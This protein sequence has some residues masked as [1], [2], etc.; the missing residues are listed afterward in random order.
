MSNRRSP[1][2][3][4]CTEACRG[5]LVWLLTFV[6]SA[7][8]EPTREAQV[9]ETPIGRSAA[10]LQTQPAAAQPAAPKPITEFPILPF[11]D[12]VLMAANELFGKAVSASVGESIASSRALTIDP[13]IDGMTAVQ[14]VATRS[15]RTRI[16]DLA[17][18]KYPE[19][20]V[21]PFTTATL[22]KS[23]LVLIGTL[24]AIDKDGQP[25]GTQ[26]NSYRIWLTLIDLRSGKIVAK[27]RARA[28]LETVDAAPTPQFRDSPAWIEDPASEAY[29]NTC[30]KGKVG[31]PI[32][33]DYLD[34]ILAAALISD[35]V[36]AYDAGRYQ[37][38]LDL[39]IGAHSLPA[40]D[41]LRVYNGIHLVNWKLGR[42]NAASEAFDD[43]VDYGLRARRLAVKFL[44]KPGST[45][46]WPDPEVSGPYS[47]W[48]QRIATRT[49]RSDA[50]LEV[51]GHAS[52]TGPE[53]LNER[54]SLLRAEYVKRRIEFEE[55]ALGSRM[56]AN[57]V[58]SRENLVG[59]GTDD[60]IDALDRR[61]EFKMPC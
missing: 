58:G 38:A 18:E 19:F 10:L 49:M 35:A 29:V 60:A 22:A 23:P 44:F 52:R 21:Q 16:V 8:Q 54:L 47:L 30:H 14:S 33:Q 45:A 43:I 27:A 32:P 41:Q 48:L 42:H 50:C 51:T 37:E 40:G 4:A 12:A 25:T 36:E 7:C 28:R 5:I 55:P 9:S 3:R 24:T 56:I 57:G 11:Q 34:R 46:F 2:L 15:M 61:V 31:D 1:T 13:L 17:R 59:T 53:P 39:Y 20:E 26:R 6:L